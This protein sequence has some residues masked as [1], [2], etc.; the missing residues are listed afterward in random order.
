M[1]HRI[2]LLN[3]P[4]PVKKA[5]YTS[6]QNKV[7]AEVVE[8]FNK[9][10]EN[11]TRDKQFGIINVYSKTLGKTGMSNGIY[12]CDDT[13]LGYKALEILQSSIDG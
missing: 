10:L 11:H 12:H 2:S 4:A 5:K 1:G 3:V 8:I 7:S 9:V 6:E 13:H